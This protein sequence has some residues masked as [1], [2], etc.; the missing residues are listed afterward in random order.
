MNLLIPG[1]DVTFPPPSFCPCT[2]PTPHL[3]PLHTSLG[4]R[5]ALHTVLL[6]AHPL[7]CHTPT[8][9]PVIY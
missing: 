5:T 8:S 2:P 9:Q 1:T 7:Q 3:L 6:S 4:D